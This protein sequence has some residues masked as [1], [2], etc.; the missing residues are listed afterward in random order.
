MNAW[1]ELAEKLFSAQ[2]ARKH[3]EDIEHELKLKL[4]EL[5]YDK[6]TTSDLFI[7]EKITRPGNVDY[8]KITELS[9]VNL[10]LYRKK[11]IEM[12]K[13]TKK[14]E[15]PNFEALKELQ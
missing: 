6:T 8:S 11:S 12:W 13:L 15:L 2:Q 3:F 9:G 10:D 7:F 4:R 14:T 1:N 5:S